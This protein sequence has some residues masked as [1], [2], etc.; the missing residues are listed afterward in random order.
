VAT[1]IH[2]PFPARPSGAGRCC[3]AVA[4]RHIHGP[5]TRRPFLAVGCQYRGGTTSRCP[6]GSGYMAVR[7]ITR[8]LVPAGPSPASART[9]RRGLL[10]A[11]FRLRVNVMTSGYYRTSRPVTALARG[12]TGSFAARWPDDEVLVSTNSAL[13][14]AAPM[15]R[16]L[17]LPFWRRSTGSRHHRST[18]EAAVRPPGRWL[19]ATPGAHLMM[20]QFRPGR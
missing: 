15:C 9:R 7:S 14:V 8:S 5:L 11:R 18:G 4:E 17:R 19:R 2:P 16:R 20:I 1:E 3:C 12:G 10:P 13:D 6:P